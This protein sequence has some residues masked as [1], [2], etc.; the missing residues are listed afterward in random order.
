MHECMTTH[1]V[2]CTCITMYDMDVVYDGQRAC[3]RVEA[4]S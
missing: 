3:W 1:P 2:D 4:P